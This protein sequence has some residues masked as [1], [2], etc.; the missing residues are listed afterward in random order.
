[1]LFSVIIGI[2]GTDL[3]SDS[4]FLNTLAPTLSLVS[5]LTLVFWFVGFNQKSKLD[6]RPRHGE[7]G[8]YFGDK[9]PPA[10]TN[11]GKYRD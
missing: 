10:E 6:R 2:A 5:M 11:D 7:R 3:S 1:M 9:P 8:V 4:V